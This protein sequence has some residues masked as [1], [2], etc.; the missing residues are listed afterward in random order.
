MAFRIPGEAV[1]ET[2]FQ[3]RMERARKAQEEREKGRHEQIIRQIAERERQEKDR[4]WRERTAFGLCLL[5]D[6]LLCRL[7]DMRDRNEPKAPDEPW[8]EA[9]RQA[10]RAIPEAKR[11][12]EEMSIAIID[13][14]GSE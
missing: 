10:V 1:G 9:F 3:Q 5:A 14:K 7:K 2:R 12:L 6:K 8:N 13:R 4:Q 11:F